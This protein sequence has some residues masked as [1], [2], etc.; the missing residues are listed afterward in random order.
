MRAITAVLLAFSMFSRLPVPRP[1]WSERNLKY[2][3]AAFPLVGAA[4]GFLFLLWGGLAAYLGFGPFLYGVVLALLP[5]AVAGGIHMD[6]FCDTIDALASRGDMQKKQA[7]LKDPHIGSFAAV[8]ASAYL[9]LFAALGSE[10]SGDWHGLM[11]LASACVLSRTLAGLA[12]VTFPLARSDG[13]AGVFCKAADRKAVTLCLALWL[14][15]VGAF[16]PV[17]GGWPGLLAV[18]GMFALF[19]VYRHIAMT[20]FGGNSGDLSGWFVQM[21]EI[22]SLLCL[23]VGQRAVELL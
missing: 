9:L 1:E 7:I 17:F 14:L 15:V 12:T 16:M 11:P 10:L 6:G 13:L 23:V 18:G 3:L 21:S 4:I 19:A 2:A 22:V 5:L 20:E 8:A